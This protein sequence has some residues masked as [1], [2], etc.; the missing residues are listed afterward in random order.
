MVVQKNEKREEDEGNE[1]RAVRLAGQISLVKAKTKKKKKRK[2]TT[3]DFVCLVHSEQDAL[4]Q[5]DGH[6][7]WKNHDRTAELYCTAVVWKARN[8]RLGH[9]GRSVERNSLDQASK[10]HYVNCFSVHFYNA[11]ASTSVHKPAPTCI[12]CNS[13]GS[14]QSYSR[15]VNTTSSNDGGGCGGPLD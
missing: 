13:T 3:P 5:D 12:L 9:L 2:T 14:T 4:H 15:T 6:N 8:H 1:P 10:K 7:T 11:T